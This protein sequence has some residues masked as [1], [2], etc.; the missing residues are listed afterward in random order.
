MLAGGGAV[1][2]ALEVDEEGG[3]EKLFAEV[4]LV[5]ILTEGGLVQVLKL[6]EREFVR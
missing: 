3:L 5:E 4:S 6:A 1:C 2:F